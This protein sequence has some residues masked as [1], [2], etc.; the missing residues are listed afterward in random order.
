ME[1]WMTMNIKFNIDVNA[2]QKDFYNDIYDKV[3]EYCETHKIEISSDIYLKI[4]REYNDYG[5]Y[6]FDDTKIINLNYEN[7]KSNN[8]S[9]DSYYDDEKI[10]TLEEEQERIDNKKNYL[11]LDSCSY[12]SSSTACSLGES[13]MDT[14]GIESIELTGK[15]IIVFPDENH[16]NLFRYNDIVNKK[17]FEKIKLI[18]IHF[19]ENKNLFYYLYQDDEKENYAFVQSSAFP[20]VKNEKSKKKN[21]LGCIMNENTGLY[22]CGI[23]FKWNEKEETECKPG[24]MCIQC[25]KVNQGKYNIARHYLINSLGR[26]TKYDGS[27]FHCYGHF[28]VYNENK[29]GMEIK[30][31]KVCRGK[32]SCKS[33][34]EIK[35][36]IRYYFTDN[37][38]YKIEKKKRKG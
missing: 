38:I 28:S 19:K 22:F 29:K 13:S 12:I 30:E 10:S 20:P 33:C 5:F 25:L 16:E 8:I 36:Y 37:L 2:I 34:Q 26:A 35:K 31:I 27:L 1:D 4:L 15:S 3:K 17:N 24:S 18:R 21:H 6:T 32:F 14:S 11:D 9:T 23:K 7:K